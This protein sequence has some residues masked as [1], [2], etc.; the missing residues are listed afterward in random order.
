MSYLKCIDVQALMHDHRVTVRRCKCQNHCKINLGNIGS[1]IILVLIHVVDIPMDRGELK[2]P[3]SNHGSCAS[4]SQW[5]GSI[6]IHDL[7]RC[8]CDRDPDDE[9]EEDD[10][11]GGN[12]RVGE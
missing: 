11:V 7:G 3:W 5:T 1:R 12:G 6:R 10:A 4:E 2:N 8:L 9:R